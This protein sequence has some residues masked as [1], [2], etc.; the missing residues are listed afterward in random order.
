VGRE[1]ERQTG[2]Q[3]DKHAINH[4]KEKERERKI[5]KEREV[6]QTVR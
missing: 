3:T 4:G 6:G 2:G 5:K 1:R